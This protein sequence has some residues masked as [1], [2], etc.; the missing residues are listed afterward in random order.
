MKSV[1]AMLKRRFARA[2]FQSFSCFF[3]S[4][5]QALCTTVRQFTKLGVYASVRFFFVKI[6]PNAALSDFSTPDQCQSLPQNPH[7]LALLVRTAYHSADMAF[8]QG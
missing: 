6:G 1:A 7:C 5:M 3:N 4:V 8:I 2:S